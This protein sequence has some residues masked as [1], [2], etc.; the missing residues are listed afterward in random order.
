MEDIDKATE[1]IIEALT[2]YNQLTLTSIKQSMDKYKESFAHVMRAT[3]L[4]AT[5]N[6][7][8]NEIFTKK[9]GKI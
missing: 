9:D 1:L 5:M 4:S 7:E 2:L 3:I 6:D 8:E